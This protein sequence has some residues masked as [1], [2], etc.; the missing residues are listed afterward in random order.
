MAFERI[1][2]YLDPNKYY[3]R[4]VYTDDEIINRVWDKE[5][6][7]NI[8]GR[9]AFYYANDQRERE[10]DELWVTKTENRKTACF[11]RNWGYYIGMDA[12]KQYYVVDHRK[13]EY[14]M[15]EKLDVPATSDNLGYGWMGFH[16]VTTP[17]IYIAGD[18]RTAKGLWICPGVESTPTGDGN[19]EA[20]WISGT[21]G[22]DFIKEDGQWKIWHLVACNDVVVKAGRNFSDDPAD[23]ED[24]TRAEFGTP[25]LD[26]TV[27]DHR[28]NWG[29][30][31]PFM[32]KPYQTFSDAISYG[33][34]GNPYTPYYLD[35][36]E[37]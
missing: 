28:Y 17:L 32:P 27:H 5:E 36:E 37:E 16:T 21:L 24:P 2:K 34:E 26:R 14:E 23:D 20:L 4:N 29:D 13:K 10:L 12:I 18:G 8:V 22:I 7:K 1:P 3:D 33:P 19:A 25:T 9:R 35:L 6:I 31:F 15:L 11:G 30:D